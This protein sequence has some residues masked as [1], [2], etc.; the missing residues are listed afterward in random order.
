M[1]GADYIDRGLVFCQPNGDYLDPALVSQTIVRMQKAG[2]KNASLHTLRHTHA[3]VL[4]SENAP[5]AAISARLGHADVSITER[6]YTH[7]VEGD[8]RSSPRTALSIL[9]I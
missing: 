1:F 8:D 9:V 4:R 6:I 7:Q 2:I 5:I 3:S